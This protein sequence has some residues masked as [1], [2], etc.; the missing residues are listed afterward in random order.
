MN[1]TIESLTAHLNVPNSPIQNPVHS[2]GKLESI[3]SD[4]QREVSCCVTVV[5]FPHCY[6]LT[7]KHTNC[8]LT[9]TQLPL[10]YFHTL[11]VPFP[12]SSRSLSLT[13]PI[14]S[15]LSLS[16]S[17]SYLQPRSPKIP[18]QQPTPAVRHLPL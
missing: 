13:V 9:N 3:S 6:S 1:N 14:L 2:V 11:S 4:I 18:S 16:H 15:S 5:T 12:L 17:H 8:T 10:Q 7:H